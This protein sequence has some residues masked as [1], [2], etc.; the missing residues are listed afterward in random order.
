MRVHSGYVREL[1]NVSIT[2]QNASIPV[3]PKSVT[4]VREAF[5]RGISY[6]EYP[7]PL[8]SMLPFSVVNHFMA[9]LRCVEAPVVHVSLMEFADGM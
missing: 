9:F 3:G 6:T 5:P 1:L 4:L 7:T 8:F 2:L